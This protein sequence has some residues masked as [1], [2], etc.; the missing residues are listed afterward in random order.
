MTYIAVVKVSADKRIEKYQDFATQAEATAHVVAVLPKFPDAYSALHPGGGFGDWLCDTVAKTL[1]ISPVLVDINARLDAQ[2]AALEGNTE[3]GIRE[4]ILFLTAA[5]AARLG[6][7]EPQLYAA[8][9]GYRKA[10]DLD[11][12]IAALRAQRV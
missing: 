4:A 10:K 3:R 1:T 7:T 12:A 9:Y 2:L 6:M 11:T 8:N 5:E